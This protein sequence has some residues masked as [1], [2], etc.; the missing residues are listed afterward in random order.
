MR[1]CGVSIIFLILCLMV[2]SAHGET[3]TLIVEI[4]DIKNIKGRISIGLYRDRDGFPEPGETYRGKDIPVTGKT[5]RAIFQN[6]PFGTYA[7][8]VFHDVNSNGQFD[9]GLLGTPGEAYGFSNDASATLGPP[10]F[11]AAAFVFNGG[12]TVVIKLSN[13]GM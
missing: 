1:K 7:I 13:W 11:N 12:K 2:S 6:V 8:A 5:C 9:Q 3:E 4:P 10:S